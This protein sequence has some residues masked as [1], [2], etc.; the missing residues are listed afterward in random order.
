MWRPPVQLVNMVFSWAVTHTHMLTHTLNFSLLL[1]YFPWLPWVMPSALTEITFVY[2][3][4]KMF[5]ISYAL[6]D[7]QPTALLK[8]LHCALSCGTVYC[9]Q[10]CLFVVLF[11]RVFVGG[12]V[13]TTTRNC[14]HRSSPNWVCSTGSDH[15]QL[16]KFWLSRAPGKGVLAGRNFLAP[17]YYSQRAVFVSL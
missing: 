2:C 12:S 9:D 5:C 16:I 6:L 17:P 1:V 10:S 7:T 15:L 3:C 13:T 4:S 11:V 8:F 14:V